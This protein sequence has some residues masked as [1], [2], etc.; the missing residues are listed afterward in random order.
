MAIA[1]KRLKLSIWVGTVDSLIVK[2]SMLAI[3]KYLYDIRPN[4]VVSYNSI[5][6]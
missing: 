2:F 5:L 1:G 6:D 3:V 4:C